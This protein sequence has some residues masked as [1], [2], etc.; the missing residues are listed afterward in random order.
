MPRSKRPGTSPSTSRPSPSPL[1]CI[2]S[3]AISACRSPIPNGRKQDL[4]HIADWDPSWQNTYFFEKPIRLPRGSVVKVVAHYD[5]SAHSRNPHR[6]PKLVKW[7][8][9]VTDEMCVGYIGVVKAGQDLTRP[10]E[11]DDLFDILLKQ[12]NKNRQRDQ[13]NT[14]RR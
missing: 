7:G 5:N 1:T 10:G 4:I 2:S 11:K 12:Y 6:P 9:E 8:P 3:D 14:R 13:L